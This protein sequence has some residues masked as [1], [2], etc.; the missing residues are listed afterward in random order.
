METFEME[1]LLRDDIVAED[2]KT[3]RS[4]I[5]GDGFFTGEDLFILEEMAW[6]CVYQSGSADVH[7]IIAEAR[8]GQCISVVGF[9]C[10]GPVRPGH[11]E[12]YLYWLAV[13]ERL[14]GQGLG[15][16]LL[17]EVEQGVA[18]QEGKRLYTDSVGVHDA[19]PARRFY[20]NHGYEEDFRGHRHFEPQDGHC[21]MSKRI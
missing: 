2:V 8:S 19:D 21:M 17:A 10:Y 11:K 15:S 6:E 3:L 9:A 1:V 13:E 7:F 4:L 5:E 14:R 20:T 16:A 18:A 12:F